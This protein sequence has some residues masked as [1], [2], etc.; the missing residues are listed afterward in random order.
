M[1]N[2][3]G[4]KI[5]K[6]GKQICFG[7][8]IPMDN[9]TDYYHKNDE[10]IVMPNETD[11]AKPE[12]FTICKPIDFYSIATTDCSKAHE[13]TCQHP[14]ETNKKPPKQVLFII[15]QANIQLNMVIEKQAN[16]LVSMVRSLMPNTKPVKPSCQKK[17]K[18]PQ[19]DLV[20]EPVQRP[21]SLKKAKNTS[22]GLA[23]SITPICEFL[24]RLNDFNFL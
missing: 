17:P 22:Y 18:Q 4:K 11:I 2:K 24:L 12:I 10:L 8:I 7:C 16:Q 19:H 5:G 15:N 3:I 14:C 9:D 1:G 21:F 20:D 6:V 13:T 23:F